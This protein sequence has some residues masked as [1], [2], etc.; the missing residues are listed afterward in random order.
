MP[1]DFDPRADTA[2][3]DA[4]QDVD[5]PGEGQQHSAPGRPDI[6][7]LLAEIDHWRETANR[8]AVNG[9]RCV[10]QKEQW[11]ARALEAEGIR[12]ELEARVADLEADLE[13]AIADQERLRREAAAQV[14]DGR[15]DLLKKLVSQHFHPDAGGAAD[16]DKARVFAEIWPLIKQAETGAET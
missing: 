16:P 6:P 15:L 4:R 1:L 3:L 13:V 12:E 5:D 11:K 10:R 7:D 9:K 14:D 8:Y 2:D